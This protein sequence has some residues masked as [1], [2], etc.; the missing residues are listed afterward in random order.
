M[1]FLAVL[2]TI[3]SLLGSA[4]IVFANGMSDSPGTAFQGGWTIAIAWT[5]TVALWLGWAFG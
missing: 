2:A 3:V 5:I 1:I 4:F